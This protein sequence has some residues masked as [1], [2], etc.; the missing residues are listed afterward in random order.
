MNHNPLMAHPPRAWSLAARPALALALLFP[1][2][3]DEERAED[4]APVEPFTVTSEDGRL[5]L[6]FEATAEEAAEVRVTSSG[7][8]IEGVFEGIVYDLEP[9]GLWFRVPAEIRVEIPE[10]VAIPSEGLDLAKVVALVVEGELTPALAHL[11]ATIE[12]RTVIG[13]IN[14]LGSVGVTITLPLPA[15][16]NLAASYDDCAENLRVTWRHEARGSDPRDFFF[17]E[18]VISPGEMPTPPAEDDDRWA[19]LGA[20][21]ASEE[22]LAVDDNPAPGREGLSHFVRGRYGTKVGGVHL[23]KVEQLFPTVVARPCGPEPRPSPI[24]NPGQ[25]LLTL[26][27]GPEGSASVRAEGLDDLVGYCGSRDDRCEY[28]LEAGSRLTISGIPHQ[29]EL[30][31]AFT[32]CDQVEGDLCGLTLSRDRTITLEFR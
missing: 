8:T 25:P 18:R 31:V 24:E 19:A 16:T 11:D 15:V 21:R 23:S 4:N 14:G 26:I 28:R 6:S 29:S 5:T 2:A 3:C 13:R 9:T 1:S 7:R 32:G 10:G 27:K 17:V 12:G 20:P 22:A 30:A